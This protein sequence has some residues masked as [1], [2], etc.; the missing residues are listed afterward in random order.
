MSED[1]LLVEREGPVTVLT[2]NRP[3]AKNALDRALVQAL[4]RGL[5]AAAE[6][7][8]ARAV[9]LT[10]AGSAFCSGADLKAAMA[11]GTLDQLDGT[12][13]A[14]H[15]MIRAIVGA[16][17]PVIA[18]VDGGAVGFGCDLALACD[19]RVLS[20]GAYLQEIFVRIGLMPDGGGT[21]WLPRL[22]GLGRALE[23]MLL[24]ERVGARDARDLGLANRV[25]PPE[26]LR[27]ETMA[28]AHRLAKGPPL[29]LA[30]IKRAARAGLGGTIDGTL[31]MEKAGQIRCLTS[32]DAIE[33]VMAWMQ[34]REPSFQGK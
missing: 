3:R 14:Y 2:L 9:V 6:D 7:P 8:G 10:G 31:A 23:L 28:L 18:A 26:S 4:G 33:G 16:P 12:I 32:A 17:K 15:A 30:E 24:G 29:A 19:M 1:V 34:R 27:E 22:V 20:T 21:F 11:E 25:V 13:D 5:A